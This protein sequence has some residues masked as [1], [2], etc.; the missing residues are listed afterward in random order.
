M[1]VHT[2]RMHS[3]CMRQMEMGSGTLEMATSFAFYIIFIYSLIVVEKE[4][5]TEQY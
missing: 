2:Q 4:H 3:N 1:A 5:I